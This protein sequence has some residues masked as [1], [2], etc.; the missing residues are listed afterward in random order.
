MGH[1]ADI[2]AMN[3]LHTGRGAATAGRDSSD[4]MVIAILLLYT[5]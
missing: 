2:N 1:P 3:L 4:I 5:D